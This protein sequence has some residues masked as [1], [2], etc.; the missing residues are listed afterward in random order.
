MSHREGWDWFQALADYLRDEEQR[1]SEVL[2]IEE[3]YG[4]RHEALWAGFPGWSGA[5][6]YA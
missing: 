1:F 3:F 2:T 5:G 4:I 6:S